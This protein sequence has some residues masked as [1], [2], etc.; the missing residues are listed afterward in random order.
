MPA[1]LAWFHERPRALCYAPAM[2]EPP[3]P[4]GVPQ[5]QP[6]RSYLQ[7]LSLAV[8]EFRTPASVV[9]GY[10]RMLLRDADPS[11]NERQRKMVE[12]AEKSCERLV[13]LIGELNEISQL[14][15]GRVTLGQQ[16]FDL[17]TVVREVAESVHE[18]QERDVRL[19]TRGTEAGA[20]LIGD[21]S[22][23]RRALSA[24][25]QAILREQPSPCRV[26]VDRRLERQGGANLA[27]I[28]VAPESHVQQAYESTAGVFDE[29]RGGLGMMLPIARRIVEKHGG[30]IWSPEGSHAR[31]SAIISLPSGVNR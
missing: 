10:L 31:G 7:L 8:H 21:V 24:I 17:F 27:V 14:D 3:E 23:L 25:F 29:T 9:G 4:D 28:V 2:A 30:R 11:L 20:W 13:A 18:A 5:S 22:R 26:V 19:E 1:G 12:E 15:A 16:P 6:A